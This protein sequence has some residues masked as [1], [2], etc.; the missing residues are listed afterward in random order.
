G[1]NWADLAVDG[2]TAWLL[3]REGVKGALLRVSLSPGMAPM[4]ERPGLDRPSGLWAGGGRVC[5]VEMPPPASPGL[6]FVPP[7]GSI[8]RFFLREASGQVRS[9]AEWP[10]RAGPGR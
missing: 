5:W 7:A 9:L 10:A 4:V 1:R 3:E 8:A 6:E 2:D